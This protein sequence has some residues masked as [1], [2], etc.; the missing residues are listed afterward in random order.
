L[1]LNKVL[2]FITGAAALAA[3][4]ACGVVAAAFT[5]Y[6]LARNYV[7][8]AGASAVVVG[9]VALVFLIVGLAAL[10][11][12]ARRRREPNITE[13]IIE[14][15]REKPL[16]S[17]AAALAAGFFALRNPAILVAILMAFLDSRD[18]KRS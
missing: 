11:K 8:P 14:F 1:S 4:A 2:F 6:A 10:I 12:A 18:G 16:A 13:R 3:A 9:L 15:I 17:L 5:V 7:G